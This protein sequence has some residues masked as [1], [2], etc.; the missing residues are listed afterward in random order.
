MTKIGIFYG[1]ST[2]ITRKIS[3]ELAEILEISY[4]DIHN[5]AKVSI[6][7]L[8][9]YDL[10]LL[11]SSTWGSGDLQDDW[12]K[13]LP[14]LEQEN[15]SD[16]TI[17]IYGSGDETMQFTFCDAVG[18][19]YERLQQTGAKFIEG[20]D[21]DPYIFSTSAAL[22]NGKYVGL[23]LDNINQPDQTHNRLIQWSKK[24]MSYINT[25]K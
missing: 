16:K 19:L 23:L 15:L 6:S 8:L 18:I 9:S 3:L 4:C 22:I 13:F 17:G 7:D 5:I 12:E 21:A 11:G 2:G 10:L 24:V 25:N 14:R 1:S 20:I